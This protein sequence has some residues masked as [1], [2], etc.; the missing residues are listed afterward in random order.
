MLQFGKKL[1]QRLSGTGRW[2]ASLRGVLD[3][4][5]ARIGGDAPDPVFSAVI[6]L[7]KTVLASGQSLSPDDIDAVRR[8]FSEKF[9]PD[10]VYELLGSLKSAPLITPAEAAPVLEALPEEDKRR[11]LQAL[12][13]L[14]S[15]LR[16]GNSCETLLHDLA[17]RI[18]FDSE[19]WETLKK[20]ISD[21]KKRRSLI[22]K[23][24]AGIVVA[25]GVIVV[26]ILTA[27]VLKSVLFGLI[28]AYIMLP[29]EQFFEK[30]LRRRK[31]VF[32]TVFR[33]FAL[34]FYP[35][36][37][38]SAFLKRR[39]TDGG[40]GDPDAERRRVTAKAVSL[41]GLTLFC[42]VVAAGCGIFA[43]SGTYVRN[44][45]STVSSA[46]RHEADAVKNMP[47]GNPDAAS[48]VQTSGPETLAE[49]ADGGV[50]DKIRLFFRRRFAAPAHPA[51]QSAEQD[52]IFDRIHRFL[53]L[54][55]PDVEK[56][57]VISYAVDKLSVMLKDP[58]SQKRLAAYVL[59]RTGGV[60]SLAA[61]L[62]SAVASFAV[63]LLLTVFFFLLFLNKI[64]VF[65]Y[66][67]KSASRPNEYIVRLVF[68]GSWMP[69]TGDD[70]LN[71]AQRIIGEV[72][73]KLKV[74]LRGYVTLISID[75]V[76]Y[77]AA[78]WLFGVP[79][80]FILGPVT[81]FCVLLPVIGPLSATVLAML[82]TLAAGGAQ[83]SL[84][85]L[86]G[87]FGIYL[88]QNAIVEQ[89]I[90]YPLVFGEALGLSLLETIIVVLLGGIFAGIPGM[91]FALP[92]AAVLKYLIP[93]IYHCWE[94]KRES[95]S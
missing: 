86:A 54:H 1:Y 94:A 2:T 34:L 37:R 30:R 58:E 19:A 7:V 22:I 78:Y 73:N 59:S 69:K 55:R 11:I 81:A 80:F 57:P 3:V 38:F 56:N 18:G 67:N 28:L 20:E 43:L 47:H 53:E 41:T 61:G 29:L 46:V 9:T 33:V 79:Y 92:T 87:I 85:P 8:Q 62:V 76:V 77:T 32:Y 82:V 84:L 13:R 91:I 17:E 10:E 4:V 48:A 88:V 93:Q 72:I 39:K 16:S 26:F 12:F 25:V 6:S 75:L 31:G 42:I 66:D 63:N 24:G 64:A 95:K 45:S 40:S 21:E 68:S 70:V 65:C 27:T 83:A 50:M 60:F 35:L 14:D 23:S 90:L 15:D 5:H 44:I 49:G 89:F 74:W 51:E 52:G 71:E 36:A